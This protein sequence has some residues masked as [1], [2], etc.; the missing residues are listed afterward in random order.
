MKAR[1]LN[2]HINTYSTSISSK[3]KIDKDSS[4]TRVHVG[5]TCTARERVHVQYVYKN[6]TV[7]DLNS[8]EGMIHVLYTYTY[9]Y[10]YVYT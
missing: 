5:A 8:Y 2:S 6:T 10:T 4:P 9:V 1:V 3:I 7:C